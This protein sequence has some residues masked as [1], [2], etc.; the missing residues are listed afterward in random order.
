MPAYSAIKYS[1]PPEVQGGKWKDTYVGSL[2]T[3]GKGPERKKILSLSKRTGTDNRGRAV[4]SKAVKIVWS[5]GSEEDISDKVLYTWLPD[6][7]P[8]TPA[9]R[10]EQ[11]DDIPF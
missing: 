4:Y 5:D 11:E 6:E 3:T 10:A 1:D 7:E 8:K 2:M 9:R